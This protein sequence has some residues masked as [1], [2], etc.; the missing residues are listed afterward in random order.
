MARAEERYIDIYEFKWCKKER[1]DEVVSVSQRDCIKCFH[2]E[3][4]LFRL[5]LNFLY[6]MSILTFWIFIWFC[7]LSY[8]VCVV[9]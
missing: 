7:C 8:M 6:V 5:N 4:L 3:R 2:V 1:R 9:I